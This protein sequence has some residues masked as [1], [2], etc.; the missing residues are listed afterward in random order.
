MIELPRKIV[1]CGVTK[2]GKSTLGNL[3]QKHFGHIPIAF[4]DPL[5]QAAKE[6]FG[7]SDTHLYGPSHERSVPYK[8]FKYSGWCFPCQKQCVGPERFAVLCDSLPAQ[9]EVNAS[10][11][12]HCDTCLTTYP[13]YVTPRVA[14][15][16]LGTEWGRKFCGD[17]WSISLFRRMAPEHS[18]VVTDCRFDNER[19]QSRRHGACVVLLKRGLAESTSSHASEAELR[20]MANYTDLFHIVLDN[21]EGT[22]SQNFMRLLELLQADGHNSKRNLPCRRHIEWKQYEGRSLEEM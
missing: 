18:Y 20:D 9:D 12:W 16:T 5:K 11:Y 2:A 21:T 10:D 17:L 7:F 15:Q 6:I 3:F 14:L 1:F 22:P 4:A 19:E 8:D 13:K